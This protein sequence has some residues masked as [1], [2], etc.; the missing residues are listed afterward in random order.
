MI[1]QEYR[2]NRRQ[3]SP[4]QLVMYSGSWVAFSAD[5]C[6]IVASGESVDRLDEQLAAMG[7]D[8]QGVVLEWVAAPENDSLVGGDLR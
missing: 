4:A 1:S 2:T 6:R 7:Q 3:F 8:G 5:G